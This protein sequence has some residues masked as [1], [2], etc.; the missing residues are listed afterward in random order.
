MPVGVGEAA[1][2]F[3]GERFSDVVWNLEAAVGEVGN[4]GDGG[5]SWKS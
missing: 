3:G 1:E 4:D 2:M 5:D